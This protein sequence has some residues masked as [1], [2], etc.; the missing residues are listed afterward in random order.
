MQTI[1]QQHGLA[2]AESADMIVKAP[3][4]TTINASK[5]TRAL[6]LLGTLM[7]S[8]L[9]QVLW[10]KL[11]HYGHNLFFLRLTH[12]ARPYSENGADG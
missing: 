6:R 7:D 5:T 8:H 11:L 12:S 10:L 4:N 2:S 1:T 9:P 3:L